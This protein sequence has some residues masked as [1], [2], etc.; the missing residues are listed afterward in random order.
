M[1]FLK[2]AALVLTALFIAALQLQALAQ[3]P[4]ARQAPNHPNVQLGQYTLPDPFLRMNAWTFVAPD[5]WQRNGGVYW[6]GKLVPVAYYSK[7]N[8]SN[9][10]GSEQVSLFPT[11]IFSAANHPTLAVGRP[12]SPYLQADEAVTRIL[13]RQFR[14]T[15]ERI[16]VIAAERNPAQLMREAAARAQTQGVSGME[17]RSARV[18]LEYQEGRRVMREM[19][20]CTL[21]GVASSGGIWAVE[22]A[23]G[24]RAE[25]SRFEDSYPL[26]G[27]IASSLR[28][29]QQW[30][31]ARGRQLRSMI[32]PPTPISGA[33]APSILDV[34]RSISRNNDQF[35]KNI[36]AIHTAR[37][38][39][40]ASDGW[41][42]A[43]RGTERMV[44][45]S[46]QE[47]ME[48][49]SGYL[50]YYQDYSGRVYGSNDPGDFYQQ[51]K[52][53]GTVLDRAQ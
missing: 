10:M 9:P 6:T 37:L 39:S 36:D 20:F 51:L 33:G 49:K 27:L 3:Q 17:V 53:G 21:A 12:I 16:S 24:A 11:M 43:F 44:N 47:A 5:D 28:E 18:L 30:V 23:I 40:P 29:N 7:L 2:S 26:L 52:I 19:F 4:P 42:R 48:V 35:L 50:Q 34:S 41:T 15:A 31:L 38:N 32:P 22:R 25:K 14:P 13:M 8:V 1:N 46:T 45:P